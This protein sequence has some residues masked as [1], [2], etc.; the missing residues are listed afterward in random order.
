LA[1]APHRLTG[2]TALA[3]PLVSGFFTEAGRVESGRR[4]RAV[5]RQD[6]RRRASP[7]GRRALADPKETF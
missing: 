7:R 4:R 5:R 3:A 2:R 1:S 6:G